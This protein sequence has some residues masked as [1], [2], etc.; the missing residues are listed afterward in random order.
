MNEVMD[1]EGSCLGH[2]VE[3]LEGVY[4]VQPLKRK[5]EKKKGKE[6]IERVHGIIYIN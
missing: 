5:M 6:K 4:N 3:I 2:V 1:Q